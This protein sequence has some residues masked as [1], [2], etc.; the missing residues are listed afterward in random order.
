MVPSKHFR[1]FFKLVKLVLWDAERAENVV[2]SIGEIQILTSASG[3]SFYDVRNVEADVPRKT[4]I[5]ADSV[6]VGPHASNFLII[7]PAH[8]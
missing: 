4:A 6:M 5:F 2:K 7:G 1:L 3:A 8:D